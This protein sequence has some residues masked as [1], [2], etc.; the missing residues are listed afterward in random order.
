VTGRR[1][2]RD[3]QP[4]P[5]DILPTYQRVGAAWAAARG[6]A[7]V[8]RPL[9]DRFLQ[10]APGR[11]ILDLGCG[12]GDPIA[13]ALVARGCRVTGVDGA[14]TMVDLFAANLPD[15]RAIHA[16]MR[17]LALGTRFDGILAFDSFF[18]L[19]PDDQ[20]AMFKVF[21]AHAMPGAALLLTTGPDAGV[22]YGTVAGEAVYHA[23]LAPAE[24]R[25]LMAANGFREIEFR[26]EDPECTGHTWWL[27]RAAD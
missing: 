9:L 6:K 15:E 16:D 20:R 13:R 18:H 8:E 21:A 17:T 3:I 5:Q 1:D 7:L 2:P 26:P 24:Y 10:I 12:A 4:T 23:S 19:A 11:R 22:V 14:R 27:A 25:A